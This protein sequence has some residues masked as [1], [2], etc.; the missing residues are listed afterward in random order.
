MVMLLPNFL[1]LDIHLDI[2]SKL[3]RPRMI[4]VMNLDIN[5]DNMYK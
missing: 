5:L 3:K 1:D 2:V 4:I